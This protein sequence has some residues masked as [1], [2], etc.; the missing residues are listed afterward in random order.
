VPNAPRLHIAWL[1]P[2]VLAVLLAGVA[3]WAAVAHERPVDTTELRIQVEQLRSQAAE[4]ELLASMSTRLAASVFMRVH[5]MQLGHR[6]DATRGDLDTLSPQPALT[7]Q[8]ARARE[9]GARLAQQVQALALPAGARPMPAGL[10]T[11]AAPLLPALKALE[12]E[13][14]R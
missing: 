12:R 4:A 14:R 11:T 5:A 3:T 8:A 2:A 13:L 6:V 1:Q 7:E 9:L 10:A